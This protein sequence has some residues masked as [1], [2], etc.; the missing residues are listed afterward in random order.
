M[1]R[2]DFKIQAANSRSSGRVLGL[3]A[4]EGVYLQV[5]HEAVELVLGILVLVL[6][7]AD[8]HADLAGHVSDAGAPQEPVQAG[9]HTD[10]LTQ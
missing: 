7:S 5:L 6:L 2:E 10:V 4:V 8:S 3:E 9:V 1:G